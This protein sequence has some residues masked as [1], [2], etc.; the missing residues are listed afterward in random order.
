MSCHEVRRALAKRGRATASPALAAHLACCEHCR[1]VEARE[2][3]LDTL[4][5]ERLPRYAAPRALVRRLETGI[6]ARSTRRRLKP[7]P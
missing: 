7:L 5:A 1:R 2:R 3:V 4:L 6:R